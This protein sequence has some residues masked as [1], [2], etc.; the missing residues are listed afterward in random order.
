MIYGNYTLH[1]LYRVHNH[2]IY[3]LEET[4]HAFNTTYLESECMNSGS[5][6]LHIFRWYIYI[7]T[8]YK[9]IYIKILQYT[10]ILAECLHSRSEVPS[11]VTSLRLPSPALLAKEKAGYHAA[12]ERYKTVN[13][14]KGHFAF[15]FGG[16]LTWS[17]LNT[18]SGKRNAW[19]SG[20]SRISYEILTTLFPLVLEGWPSKIEVIK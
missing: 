5:F 1:V 19:E 7:Y 11:L 16:G 18:Q 12:L 6:F 10:Y 9:Y 3:S 2:A 4:Y 13:L 14:C 17:T 20:L 15:F 8:Y